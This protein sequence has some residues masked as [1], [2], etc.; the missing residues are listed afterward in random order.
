MRNNLF[1]LKS[2]GDLYRTHG[3][4]RGVGNIDEQ[5]RIPDS[6]KKRRQVKFSDNER[7][8]EE[9]Y[10]EEDNDQYY[11]ENE[12]YYQEEENPEERSQS[13]RE[14]DENFGYLHQ[15]Y[16][17]KSQRDRRNFSKKKKSKGKKFKLNFGRRG[18]SQSARASRTTK[19]PFV[20]VDKNLLSGKSKSGMFSKSKIFN[21]N[22]NFFCF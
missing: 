4:L 20:S 17:I 15:S 22:F 11:D 10:Y 14:M 9:N 21:L 18:A 13:Y 16:Q 6:K 5:F 12:D 2:K 8:E 3:N 7:N 19:N 1:Y